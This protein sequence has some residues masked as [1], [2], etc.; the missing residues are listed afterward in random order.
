[1]TDTEIAELL[2]A[3][4][5]ER[6]EDGAII[7]REGEAGGHIFII[8]MGTVSIAVTGAVDHRL[9]I[10][11]MGKGS[12]F[13][14]MAWMENKPR[15]ATVIASSD[16]LLLKTPFRSF[17]D[18][19]DQNA[20]FASK[21]S[22]V[23]SERL[24]KLTE[25]I[26]AVRLKDVDEKLEL[27]NTKLDASLRAMESQMKAAETMFDQTSTRA[28]DVIQS[29]DRTRDQMASVGKVAILVASAILG[30]LGWLG[31]KEFNSIKQGFEEFVTGKEKNVSLRVKNVNLRA[32]D[33]DSIYQDVMKKS[34]DFHN[35]G[36][37]TGK[38]I[39]EINELAVKIEKHAKEIDTIRFV[40]GKKIAE[41]NK[42]TA[43]LSG[44]Y[45]LLVKHNFYEIVQEGRTDLFKEILAVEDQ[46]I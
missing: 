1:M 5:E 7:L 3:S 25:E 36:L 19:M 15:L 10:D 35:I 34:R 8:G 44:L 17:Q 45:T 33:F 28:G 39:T 38:K 4:D 40:T 16:C 41:Q 13:G 32:D 31:Y 37:A 43:T 26:L 18:L 6:Y 30:L 42:L 20:P 21:V 2:E 24:R 12:F 27:S 9:P 29:F 11:S 46:N 14:E 22:L 23:L